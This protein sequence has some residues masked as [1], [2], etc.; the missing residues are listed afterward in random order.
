MPASSKTSRHRQ[1]PPRTFENY[2]FNRVLGGPTAGLVPVATTAFTSFPSGTPSTPSAGWTWETFSNVTP[3]GFDFTFDG[4]TYKQFVASTAGWMVLVDPASGSFAVTDVISSGLNGENGLIK[5]TFAG[6]VVMLAPWFDELRTVANDLSQLGA[7]F[8]ATK[9]SRVRSALEPPMPQF[10]QVQSGVKYHN[11]NSIHKGRRL[12][13][14]WNV[15]SYANPVSLANSVLA[16]DVALYENGDIEFR[17]APRS[18]LSISNQSNSGEGAVVGIFA[19]KPGYKDRFRDMSAGLGYKDA[20]RVPYVYGGFVSSS[21]FSDVAQDGQIVPYA[22][23]LTPTNNWPSTPSMACTIAF[24]AP[25]LRRQVLPRLAIGELDSRISMPLVGRVG[26]PARLGTDAVFFDERN[27]AQYVSGVVVNY[28]TTLPRMFGG[29]NPGAAER[30]NLFT[31]D[32]EL[33]GSIVKS[34]VDPFLV[35]RPKTYVKPFS[36]AKQPEQVVNNVNDYFATGSS[37]EKFSDHLDQRLQSKTMIRMSLPVERSVSLL[38]TSSCIVY[39]RPTTRSWALPTNSTYIISNNA[40]GNDSGLARGDIQD[41]RGDMVLGKVL[42]D[43]R[44]FGPIGDRISSGTFPSAGSF[45]QTDPNIANRSATHTFNR[46][47]LAN[48][49][50]EVYGN[51]VSLHAQYQPTKDETFSLPITK[52][53]LLEK[54]VIEVPMAMGDGWFKNLTQ[55]WWPINLIN[56]TFDNAFDFAGPALTVALFN[57]VKAGSGTRLDLILSGVITHQADDMA[58][59]YSDADVDDPN[60]YRTRPVGYRAHGGKASA[61]VNPL[62]SS[63]VGYNFTGSVGMNLQAGVSNG[64]ILQWTLLTG[65]DNVQYE[66]QVF[67]NLFASPTI[68]LDNIAIP[69]GNVFLEKFCSVASVNP[70]SRG[71]TGFSTSYRSAFGKEYPTFSNLINGNVA[72]NPFY[73]T[74]SNPS[75]T[76]AASG[77]PTHIENIL[78]TVLT[79]GSARMNLFAA[80]PVMDYRPSPYIVNP[81]DKLVL[82]LSKMRPFY[83]K[84]NGATTSTANATTS[85]SIYDDVQLIT[86]AINITFYGSTLSDGEEHHDTLNQPLGSDAVHELFIGGPPTVADQ[87]EG[88]YRDAY[89]GSYYDDVVIGNMYV[90][91]QTWS[92]NGGSLGR[93]VAFSKSAPRSAPWSPG[94]GPFD[95]NTSLSYQL[96]PYF[97][98][99][100]THRVSQAISSTERIWDSMMPS[101]DQCLTLGGG[102]IMLV[103]SGVVTI[104]ALSNFASANSVGLISFGDNPIVNTVSP[105]LCDLNW[106]WAYPFEPRYSS[107]GRQ[108]DV[109]KSFISMYQWKGN[110]LSPTSISPTLVSSLMFLFRVFPDGT[111]WNHNPIDPTPQ[112]YEEGGEYWVDAT[113]TGNNAAPYLYV[114]GS[115]TTPDTVKFLYGFGD[116]QAMQWGTYN[117]LGGGIFVPD[118]TRGTYGWNHL[119]Y[120]RRRL[121]SFSDDI[122][123]Q[124]YS[125]GPII[126]GWKYGV[127]N[128]LPSFTKAIWRPHRYGQFR[129]MLEQ[130]LYTKLYIMNDTTLPT[131]NTQQG[132][133]VGVVNVKFVD[134]FGNLTKPENTWSFNLSLE[135]T[136]SMPY[137]D[138]VAVNRPTINTNTLN[139]SIISLK[140]DNFG[141]ISL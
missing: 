60:N 90:P 49:L 11:G 79:N 59:V 140:S 61:V 58:S 118:T 94:L 18:N 135:A 30:Q 10:N 112:Q 125:V 104:S 100:G 91:T 42:E 102:A 75:A 141:N 130:R 32:F 111:G 19:S 7:K 82:S 55:A 6:N 25:K 126:R 38:P 117:N 5:S 77:L 39:Y 87:Y 134:K 127:Y 57:Q 115:M 9:L 35:E 128:G 92:G 37:L 133:T 50:T 72:P 83:Y 36:E 137:F 34:A 107:V 54:I 44:G 8:G 120:A 139:Q 13:V 88:D 136:S 2:T 121:N 80:I 46:E 27:V 114:T 48:A 41:P 15:V 21:L 47:N 110:S 4:V 12:T 123:Q 3:I 67:R 71:A 52:P 132:E 45:S 93:G 108:V 74:G 109:S 116:R 29:T 28:P 105:F 66:T 95:V 14:R 129:D 43:H 131:N 1:P 85:G 96:Q 73:F 81:G 124:N 26:D 56:L 64:V 20:G 63:T 76:G 113:Q 62:S 23:A 17:Y 51:S 103:P 33:T 98:L 97:E 119:P 99:A 40:T 65:P 84:L 69:S 22:A 86:G 24:Q 106:P 53:F 101:I 70:I 89:S 31:G 68:I 138:G 78:A 16:F 122:H